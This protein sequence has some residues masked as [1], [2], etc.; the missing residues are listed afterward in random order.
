MAPLSLAIIRVILSFLLLYNDLLFYFLWSYLIYAYLQAMRQS[1]AGTIPDEP[2]ADCTETL[3]RLRFRCPD[4]KMLNRRFLGTTL[5]STLLNYLLSNGYSSDEY[6]VLTTFP[7][8]D[9]SIY[10]YEVFENILKCSLPS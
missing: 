7:R 6:K 3:A 10:Y 5:L 1:V 9:V 8:R 2:P 4:G